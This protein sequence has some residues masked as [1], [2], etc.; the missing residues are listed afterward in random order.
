MKFEILKSIKF[1]GMF[2]CYYLNVT[3]LCASD[4]NVEWD[5]SGRGGQQ[6][7]ISVHVSL[8]S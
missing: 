3:G 5:V 1:N 4:T 8:R 2:K 6:I 7:A